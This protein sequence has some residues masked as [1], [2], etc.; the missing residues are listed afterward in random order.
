MVSNEFAIAMCRRPILV[1]QITG[2]WDPSKKLYKLNIPDNA[3]TV[4]GLTS[5]ELEAN[6]RGQRKMHAFLYNQDVNANANAT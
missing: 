4:K 3:L 5:E 6:R 2:W 1:R